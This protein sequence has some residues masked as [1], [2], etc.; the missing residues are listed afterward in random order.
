VEEITVAPHIKNFSDL[1][2]SKFNFVNLYLAI[3]N[4][5]IEQ[6]HMMKQGQEKLENIDSLDFIQLLREWRDIVGYHRKI[7][8]TLPTKIDGIPAIEEH[9]YQFYEEVPGFY[10]SDTFEDYA[11]ALERITKLC[12]E[13]E[14]FNQKIRD[15]EKPIVWD[16][17]LGETNCKSG[18]H[19]SEDLLCLDDFIKGECSCLKKEESEEK[20]QKLQMKLN[21]LKERHEKI[22]EKKAIYP[23]NIPNFL[24]EENKVNQKM[25]Q[26]KNELKTNKRCVH[27]TDVG[28]KPFNVQLA[29]YIR[30]E[31][32]KAEEIR[33]LEQ[34][35]EEEIKKQEQEMVKSMTQIKKI[36]KPGMV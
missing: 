30:R 10:L 34:Q 16:M 35:K 29:N 24:K 31:Q 19:Y 6:K 22:Q 7:A 17:C 9:G 15:G 13:N 20:V 23:Q 18:V 26:I 28:F 14:S 11:W 21:Q 32:E 25:V 2:K 4:I 36:K 33:K 8:K 5:L 1:D 27:F 12:P 3:K